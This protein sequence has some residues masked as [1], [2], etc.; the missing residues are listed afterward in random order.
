M[1]YD[2]IAEGVDVFGIDQQPVHVEQAGPHGQEA[3]V[4]ELADEDLGGVV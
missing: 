1:Q 4:H 2:V 3:L